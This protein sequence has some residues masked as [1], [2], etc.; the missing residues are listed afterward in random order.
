MALALVTAAGYIKDGRVVFH[1]RR[2]FDLAVSGL[3]DGWEV[4]IEIA[5]LRATRSQK[6][7]A[8][9]WGTI[10]KTIS[11]HTGYRPTEVHELMKAKF[12]PKHMAI[13]K[14][15]GDILGQY[16][17]GGSTRHMDVQEFG[18]YMTEIKEWAADPHDGL[19]LYIPDPDELGYGVG[20]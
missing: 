15:N 9:Y 12:I 10:I 7:N 6:Q 1:D 14:G 4:E 18:E 20:V 2:S 11:Q 19:G 13:L 16:V 3:R 8:T 17:L 5:R